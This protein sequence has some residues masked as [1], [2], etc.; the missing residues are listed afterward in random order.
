MKAGTLNS[1]YKFLKLF[2]TQ[3][4][5]LSWLEVSKKAENAEEGLAAP[6]K[7]S[8]FAPRYRMQL[9]GGILLSC[10][11][12]LSG[13]NAVFYYSVPTEPSK[14]EEELPV[15]RVSL[16][17][18]VLSFELMLGREWD[19]DMAPSTRGFYENEELK[20]AGA[21]KQLADAVQLLP[22]APH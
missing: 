8:M 10:A 1:Q 15:E 16:W 12:Q 4:T 13:I 22:N 20:A 17:L 2:E 19:D 3:P 7:E 14:E 5:A 11:Q 6:K 18:S 9:L 21:S